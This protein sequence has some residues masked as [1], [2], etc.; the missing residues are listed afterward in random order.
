MKIP[1]R[2]LI[3]LR[4]CY[5]LT[6]TGILITIVAVSLDYMGQCWRKVIRPPVVGVKKF[7]IL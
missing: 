7:S 6:R 5:R 4:K 2:D 3:E 1:E